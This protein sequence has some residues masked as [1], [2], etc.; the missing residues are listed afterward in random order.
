MM[1]ADAAD[2]AVMV[3]PYGADNAPAASDVLHNKEPRM[4]VLPEENARKHGRAG[5]DWRRGIERRKA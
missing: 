3:S 4:Q 5:Q 1:S 2:H